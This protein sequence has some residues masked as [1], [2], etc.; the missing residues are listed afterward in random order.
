VDHRNPQAQRQPN[1]GAGKVLSGVQPLEKR[2]DARLV[3][4]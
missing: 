3:G 4:L 1:A 2:K